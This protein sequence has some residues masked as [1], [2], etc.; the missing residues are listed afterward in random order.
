MSKSKSGM[1][2]PTMPK[3]SFEKNQGKLS[4]TSNLKYASE[5][6]NPEEL[7]RHNEGLASYAKKHKAKQ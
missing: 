2:S 5:F 6:G 7:D 1:K 4:Q 3:E